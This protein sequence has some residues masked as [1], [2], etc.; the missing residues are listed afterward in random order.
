M[1]REPYF[2]WLGTVCGLPH[3]LQTL[4]SGSKARVV[5]VRLADGRRIDRPAGQ[6][7]V[8]GG[9]EQLSVVSLSPR[10]VAGGH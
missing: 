1:I 5:Q 10:R 7:G 2:G 3:E 6:C 9:I 8:D 4:E